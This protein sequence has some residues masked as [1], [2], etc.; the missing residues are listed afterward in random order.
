MT[1]SAALSVE[2]LSIAYGQG[3]NRFV[4]VRGVTLDLPLRGTLG[5]V[6]ESGSGKSTLGRAVAGFLPVHAGTIG[7]G[8]ER[9]RIGVVLQNPRASF[10]PRMTVHRALLEAWETV[11]AAQRRLGRE[12]VGAQ[13]LT[14]VGIGA[15]A[16]GR[17]PHEFS[18]GQ[19]QRIAI[20]RAL[21]AQPDVLVLDEVTSALDVGVQ[22][23]IL[24]LLRRVQERFGLTYLFISHDLAVVAQM[25]DVVAVMYVG[26]LLEVGPVADVL[27]RPR[28]PYTRAL[29]DSAPRLG[30]PLANAATPV[31]ADIPDPRQPPPGCPYWTRCA[32]GPLR[33][34]D[35][36]ICRTEV[37]PAARSD[38]DAPV[39]CHFPL[40]PDADP[41]HEG[42]AAS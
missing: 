5:L 11:P 22:A 32:H 39:A 24:R 29:L 31:E 27:Q 2:D 30:E 12:Q 13:V 16:L 35:R 6:G 7:S 21:A 23:T 33:H 42:E 1:T 10:N 4:A 15:D 3:R 17:F 9:P 8:P 37:P 19:L 25:S 18:G 41:P 14:D 40:R 36:E 28:H 38:R 34:P 26:R 20:A